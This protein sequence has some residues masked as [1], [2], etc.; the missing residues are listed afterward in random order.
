MNPWPHL[1]AVRGANFGATARAEFGMA[2]IFLPPPCGSVTGPEGI[3]ACTSG[4]GRFPE[5]E[6]L[7]RVR[8]DGCIVE[9]F[10][11]LSCTQLYST[12][13]G[14]RC[15]VS[16]GYTCIACCIALCCIA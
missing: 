14:V 15:A 10:A 4:F 6:L 13:N 11:V 8:E 2:T 16:R 5:A 3:S 12:Q 1:G 9:D 7:L